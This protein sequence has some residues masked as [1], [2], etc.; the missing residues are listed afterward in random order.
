MRQP[1]GQR[2]E[3]GLDRDGQ[4]RGQSRNWWR[5]SEEMGPKDGGGGVWGCG[6]VVPET[7]AHTKD[8]V[9]KATE[10][11]LGSSSRG[12]TGSGGAQGTTVL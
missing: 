11:R 4:G 6:G 7:G 10:P 12:Q 8:T 5:Q 1:L 3:R 2:G 9:R